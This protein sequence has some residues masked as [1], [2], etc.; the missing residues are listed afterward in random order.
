LDALLTLLEIILINIILSGDNAVVIALACRRL[1]WENRK[2]A[3]LI[4]TIGAVG[5]RVVLTFIAVYLLTIPFVNIIGSLLLIWIAIKLLR[6]EDQED[7]KASTSLFEAIKTI[8]IAD[9]VMSLD[10]VLAVAGV[11]GGSI[12]LIVL[13]LVISIPLIIWGSQILMKI[14]ERFPII[15]TLGAGLLG[16]TAGEMIFKDKAAA[17]LFE[18]IN[19]SLHLIIPIL[20]AFL[21]IF[22]GKFSSHSAK[23]AH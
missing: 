12:V 3:V 23:E 16:Y 14:M 7:V 4:G 15:V 6:G 19:P 18:D 13:G 10:N 5:L 1:P 9:L 17:N 22:I 21:V 8:I 20:L 2:K 11:A